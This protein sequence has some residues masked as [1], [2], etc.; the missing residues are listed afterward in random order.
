MTV[1]SALGV[2]SRPAAAVRT[3]KSSRVS[4]FSLAFKRE[5]K[6]ASRPITFAAS[7]LPSSQIADKRL[8]KF[9]ALFV[10][11]FPSCIV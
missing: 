2:I 6:L 9:I 1:L 10:L 4:C 5:M 7:V 3:A 11:F 8:A